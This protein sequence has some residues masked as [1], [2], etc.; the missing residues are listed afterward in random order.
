[1]TP[2]SLGA[3]SSVSLSSTLSTAVPPWRPTTV[4]LLESSMAVPQPPL[5]LAKAGLEEP[6]TITTPTGNVFF[7]P[8]KN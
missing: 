2:V 4:W 6:H 5:V 7:R 8:S 1:M 3:P